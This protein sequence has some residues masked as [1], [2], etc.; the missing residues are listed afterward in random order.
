MIADLDRRRPRREQ[1]LSE[2]D[3]PLGHERDDGH[4]EPDA[5]AG[6]HDA[7]RE[8]REEPAAED[9][10]HAE[11]H[12]DRSNRVFSGFLRERV[13]PSPEALACFGGALRNE[14]ERAHVGVRGR[15]LAGRNG[16]GRGHQSTLVPGSRP[17]HEEM[18]TERIGKAEGFGA[19]VMSM[20]FM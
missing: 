9:E 8:P 12:G 5:R 16:A 15:R 11:R 10:A 19:A 3:E 20:D 14:L 18:S 7:G 1:T 6:S 17:S 13:D 2:R 4:A